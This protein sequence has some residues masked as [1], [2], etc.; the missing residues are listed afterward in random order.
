MEPT[1]YLQYRVIVTGLQGQLED[2]YQE[3]LREYQ[4]NTTTFR[5]LSR[6]LR[7]LPSSTNSHRT[8]R[9]HLRNLRFILLSRQQDIEGELVHIRRVYRQ[10]PPLD[11]NSDEQHPNPLTRGAQVILGPLQLQ[12]QVYDYTSSNS[13]SSSSSASLDSRNN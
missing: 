10:L 6:I 11:L 3:L 5:H 13:S 8:A 12:P 1:D 2:R 4:D 7:S 9:D